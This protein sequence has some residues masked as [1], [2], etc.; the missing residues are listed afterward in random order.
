[1]AL[2]RGVS[3]LLLMVVLYF[4]TGVN[5]ILLIVFPNLAGA[6]RVGEGAPIFVFFSLDANLCVF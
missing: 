2:A 6:V 5:V 1:M 3:V 4:Q